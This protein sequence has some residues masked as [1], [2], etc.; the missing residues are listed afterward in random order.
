MLYRFIPLNRVLLCTVYMHLFRFFNLKLLKEKNLTSLNLILQGL[1]AEELRQEL[2][3]LH[4][5]INRM[6]KHLELP[7]T[8]EYL[9]PGIPLIPVNGKIKQHFEDH[10]V[11]GML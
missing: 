3:L 9:V 7:E 4:R 2:M 8:N 5:D 10:N 6:S 1:K 11:L